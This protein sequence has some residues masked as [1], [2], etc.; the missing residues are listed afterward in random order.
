MQ[1][2]YGLDFGTT[3][4]A[5]SILKDGKPEIL[6]IRPDGGRIDRTVLFFPERSETHF[7]G[8]QAIEQYV[9]SGMRGRFIRSVKSVLPIPYFTG[10]Y[11]NGKRYTAEDLVEIALR[12]F[13]GKA[14]QATGQNVT[15]VVIGRPVY[16]SEDEENDK[17]AQNRLL[18]AAQRVGFKEI[19]FQFEPIAAALYFE[20]MLTKPQLVLVAD[21]GGGTTDLTLMRMDP[22]RVDVP[23]R[24]ADVLST[25]GV[26]IGGD[27]FDS[28]I[29]RR[30]LIKHF[31]SETQWRSYN[32]WLDMPAHIFS[33]IC[34]W[35]RIP[36]LK[37]G[38]ERRM[39]RQLKS[40][41]SDRE[42][43]E[44][45]E[46]LIDEDLGFALFQEIERAKTDL[47]SA[48]KTQIQF[49]K[50]KINIKEFLSRV[51]FAKM[52]TIHL[53][54]IEKCLHELLFRAQI[55]R[56]DV[57]KIFLTGGTSC[58]PAIQDLFI[59][60]FEKEKIELG[61][62]LSSVVAGLALSTNKASNV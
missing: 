36:Y 22:K 2:R 56:S 42:A 25:N 4:S 16:F 50:S 33:D 20:T 57:D 5:V 11:I 41:A 44:R 51:E 23:N 21:L 59:S 8:S 39:I 14:D 31:G 18:E 46:A 58:V 43:M 3:N 62:A 27:N 30:K 17:L 35:R 34:D 49:T 47:S 45:L 9:Q 10:T 48:E 24:R 61:D 37:G 53:N 52:I 6:P 26:Y 15:S 55:R 54:E 40:V 60:A 13:K 12:H 29:M 28:E 32:K 1:L 19:A 7:V 38:Q